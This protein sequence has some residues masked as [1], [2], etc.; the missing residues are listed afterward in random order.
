MDEL[1]KD[2]YF[3]DLA[4]FPFSEIV[5]DLNLITDY[6]KAKE[7]VLK[8]IKKDIRCDIPE[9]V[10]VKGDVFIDEGTIIEPYVYIVGPVYIGKNVLIRSNAW[11]RPGCLIGNDVV[12]GHAMELK[13]AHLASNVKMGAST[14]VGDAIL[15]KGARVGSGTILANRRFDQED[16]SLTVADQKIP[17]NMDKFGVILGDY[18]RLGSNVSTAPG[19]VIG[20][21]TWVSSNLYVS[22]FVPSHMFLKPSQKTEMVERLGDADLDHMDKSGNI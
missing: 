22:G 8:G 11:I 7:D 17:T 15:G 19:T 4:A 14:F 21:K 13:N 16:I 20:Q 3:S 6:F 1:K 9:G 18:A 10:I 2:Y 5:Q 12:V